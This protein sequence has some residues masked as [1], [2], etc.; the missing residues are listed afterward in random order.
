MELS[1]LR[2]SSVH[3]ELPY[4]NY[5]PKFRIVKESRHRNSRL[6]KAKYY[7]QRKWLFGWHDIVPYDIDSEFYG[8]GLSWDTFEEALEVYREIEE[9]LKINR[10]EPEVVWPKPEPGS[11]YP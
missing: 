6:A 3:K 1:A 7:I 2:L 5:M 4:N 8:R 10:K 9:V 11:Y